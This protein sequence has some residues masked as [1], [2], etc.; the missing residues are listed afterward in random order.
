M[1]WNFVLIFFPFL[2]HSIY[3]TVN[4]KK[5]KKINL[6]INWTTTNL[7]SHLINFTNHITLQFTYNF[8]WNFESESNIAHNTRFLTSYLIAIQMWPQYVC[9]HLCETRENI[10]SNTKKKTHPNMSKIIFWFREEAIKCCSDKNIFAKI[11]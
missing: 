7:E 5:K 8:V 11:L 3:S 1:W 4:H 6:V 10:D 9:V 2:S